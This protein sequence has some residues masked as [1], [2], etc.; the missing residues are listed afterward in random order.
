[1]RERKDT[2]HGLHELH[3]VACEVATGGGVSAQHPEWHTVP[4]MSTLT[5]LTIA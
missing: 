3:V 4:R 2:R 1:M 5:P